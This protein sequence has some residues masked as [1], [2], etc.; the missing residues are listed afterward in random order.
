MPSDGIWPTLAKVANA[1]GGIWALAA[2]GV[3]VLGSLLLHS[4]LR[5]AARRAVDDECV[6]PGDGAIPKPQPGQLRVPIAGAVQAERAIDVAMHRRARGQ[7]REPEERARTRSREILRVPD[8][9][10]ETDAS[11]I[12][13]LIENQRVVGQ[14]CEAAHPS[15]W[16]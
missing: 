3:F 15:N 12:E 11:H 10:P 14:P 7:V 8:A 1:I 9:E 6:H 4:K 16:G 13:V 2:L 5:P